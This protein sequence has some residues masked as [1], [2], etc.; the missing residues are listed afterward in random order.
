MASAPARMR[1]D[2]VWVHATVAGSNGTACEALSVKNAL[3]GRIEIGV[4]FGIGLTM[5]SEFEPFGPYRKHWVF[6]GG[7]KL[8]V[9][10]VLREIGADAS[11]LGRIV[12][13]CE[14]YGRHQDVSW[15]NQFGAYA[16][17]GLNIRAGC[18]QVSHGRT[19]S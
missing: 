8:H 4:N 3:L 11:E 13:V 18:G 7:G 2:N 5:C 12:L 1:H 9:P 16:C 6:F 17:S 15:V 19:V 14:K 10:A